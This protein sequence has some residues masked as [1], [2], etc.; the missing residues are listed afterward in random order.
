MQ[1]TVSRG[2]DTSR[3]QVYHEGARKEQEVDSTQ[4]ALL[5]IGYNLIHT[6]GDG[7]LK[8]SDF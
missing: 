3:P 8:P 6:H 1:G 2:C 5:D 4:S 7:G